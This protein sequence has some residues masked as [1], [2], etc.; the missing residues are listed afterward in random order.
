MSCYCD[1][2]AFDASAHLPEP[3][4]EIGPDDN[5]MVIFGSREAKQ[6][7]ET[8]REL[9]E[10][11]IAGIDDSPLSRPDIIV[12]GGA[13]G[14]DRA[15]EAVAMLLGVPMIVMYVGYWNDE[16]DLGEYHDAPWVA[17][18]CTQYDGGPGPDGKAAYVARNCAMAELVSQ[19]DGC[20]F[21]L[22]VNESPGTQRMFDSL[23]SHGVHDW[24]R[25]PLST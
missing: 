13:D 19:H 9:A 10:M 3:P 18:K 14:V 21:G 15:A 16:C 11:V 20:G 24:V 6:L 1:S 12:S 2:S 22:H 23:E 8:N 25:W 7:Q 4:V 5:V 17:E